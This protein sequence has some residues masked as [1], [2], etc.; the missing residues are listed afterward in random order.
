MTFSIGCFKHINIKQLS[1]AIALCFSISGALA[2]TPKGEIKAGPLTHT[3]ESMQGLINESQVAFPSQLTGKAIY[4]GPY[5]SAP[6][7]SNAKVPVVLFMHG[8]SGLGLKAI[9]DWQQWLA[10]FG[11]ASIAPNSFALTD[12]LTYTSPIDKDTYEKLHAFRASEIEIT[13]KAL[14]KMP[15]VDVSKIVLAGTS[16]G[17][18]PVARYTGKEFAGRI[19]FAW[20]CEDNYF[21]KSH[22][23]AIPDDQPTLNIISSTDPYFSQSNTWLGNAQAVGHCGAI[24]KNNKKA[25]IVLIPGGPHTVLTFPQA[26]GPVQGFLTD[27]F[28]L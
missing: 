16:E 27:L 20:S 18:V 17:S 5:K 11:V 21:V 13:L 26:K 28:K 24:L 4:V 7:L 25:S 14:Q 9:A 23:T 10:S 19:M 15:W 1:L 6:S 12:R 22:Q 2:Q 8:S 3:Q